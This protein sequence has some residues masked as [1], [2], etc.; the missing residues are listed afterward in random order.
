[1]RAS[2]VPIC[3]G[4]LVLTGCGASSAPFDYVQVAGKVTYEDGTL[5]PAAGIRITF[6]SQTPTEDPKT[7]PRPGQAEANVADGTFETVTSYKYADGV[8]RGRH[9]VVV[10][11]MDAQQRRTDA[12]PLEYTDP[13]RTPLEVDTADAPFHLKIRKPQ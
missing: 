3:W 9:K 8:V 2:I 10:V 6:L 5:I 12:V 13:R 11:S 4:V 7:H 1:V